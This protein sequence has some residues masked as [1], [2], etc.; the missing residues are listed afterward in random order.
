MLHMVYMDICNMQV[1][2]GPV[3]I[4]TLPPGTQTTS[5]YWIP[6]KSGNAHL[7]Y[8][9]LNTCKMAAIRHL[10]FWKKQILIILHSPETI[11]Y[12]NTKFDQNR[13]MCCWVI[14]IRRIQDGRHQPH[15][16]FI[17]AFWITTKVVSWSKDAVKVWHA[18]GMYTVSQKT[19]PTFKLSVTLS[20]VNRFSKFLHCSKA[21]EICYKTYMALPTSP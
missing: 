15:W 16:I 10:E 11:F 8:C 12:L 9:N 13:A 18:C 7:S 1:S 5:V 3:F 14:K 19:L 17:F 2:P 4:T 6:S 20:N 21:Y